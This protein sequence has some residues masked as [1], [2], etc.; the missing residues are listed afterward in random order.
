MEEPDDEEETSVGPTTS[1]SQG[2]ECMLFIPPPPLPSS[3]QQQHK[4]AMQE[5][6]KH[7]KVKQLSSDTRNTIEGKGVKFHLA[8]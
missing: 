5:A 7:E 6:T 4:I 3:P 1:M 8:F 2:G